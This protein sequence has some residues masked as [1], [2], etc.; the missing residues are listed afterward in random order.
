MSNFLE[1]SLNKF[2]TSGTVLWRAR[3][4][5]SLVGATFQMFQTVASFG[6]M[7]V[8]PSE[9]VA[10]AV[11]VFDAVFARAPL[12]PR[13]PSEGVGARVQVRAPKGLLG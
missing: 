6:G 12:R 11:S 7:R 1:H 10:L 2:T 4:R 9:E 8:A 13:S 5:L 3:A